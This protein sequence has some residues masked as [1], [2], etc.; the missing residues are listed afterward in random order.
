MF[1]QIMQ[2]SEKIRRGMELRDLL[3]MFNKLM[4]IIYPLKH[5]KNYEEHVYKITKL[6][7]QFRR[8]FQNGQYFNNK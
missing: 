1:L 6:D 4:Q 3:S 2:I 8:N 7:S 5:W